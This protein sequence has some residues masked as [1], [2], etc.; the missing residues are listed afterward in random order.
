MQK[1]R[2]DNILQRS[3]D[4]FGR[5]LSSL[6]LLSRRY[7][8]GRIAVVLVGF[9]LAILAERF[10]GGW[11]S[12]LIAGVCSGLFLGLVRLHNHLK[13]RITR[14]RFWQQLKARHLAR[15]RRDWEHLPAY[16][17][18]D[19]P[20]HP[21]ATDLNLVGEHSLLQ[22][23]DTT[24]SQGGRKRLQQWFLQPQMQAPLIRARQAIVRELVPLH[25]F[26]DHL[27]LCGAL[28]A[29]TEE[30]RW[31]G[32]RVLAWLHQQ[33]ATPGLHHWVRLLGALA[34]VNL[35]LFS[36]Y[37]LNLTGPWWVLSF[38][39]YLGLYSLKHGEARHLFRDALYL[40][41]VLQHLRAVLLY[42]EQRRYSGT[43][44]LGKLCAPFWQ[45]THR[46]SM[47]L[48]QII[49]L[50]GSASLQRNLLAPA[51]NAL[52]PW[53]LYF[54]N[55]LYQYKATIKTELPVWMDIWYELEALNALAHFGYLNPAY[56]FPEVYDSTTTLEQSVFQ[57]EALGHPLLRH[58]ERVCN[59][60]AWERFGEIALITGSNMSGK[61]T[62][63][64]TLG[65]NLCLAYAGAPVNAMLL[66]T[67]V[68]R[69]FTCIKVSDSVTDG[70]SYFYA[71]VRRLK[72]LLEALRTTDAQPLCFLIDEIFRG[73]NNRE[74]LLG[75]Q[76]YIQALAG[77]H[78]VGALSTHDLELVALADTVNGLRNYHFREEVEAGKMVFDYYLHPGPCPTTNALRIMQME[79]LPVQMEAAHTR[80]SGSHTRGQSATP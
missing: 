36:L 9:T 40:E 66:H 52:L 63:L 3:F 26:R 12:W 15:L 73:T 54:A 19:E 32:E 23:L 30:R 35:T 78:G 57:G 31:E 4:R 70:I 6:N 25:S 18:A 39:L 5:R 1:R 71:E 59:N 51:V 75:S 33:P 77:G 45:A 16:P 28:V 29:Q 50:A 76:A 34:M 53:D 49:R 20:G 42:L 2:P 8:S 80:A 67:V 11:A 55:R 72:A 56:T 79:G 68:L 61:S 24:T 46:P 58:D 64:R 13:K 69:V 74:R 21:F 43:P 17:E 38:L 14:Y 7:S 60:F 47:A 48:R 22:L 41:Q 10:L 37:S 62:F 44:H 27:A 65:I